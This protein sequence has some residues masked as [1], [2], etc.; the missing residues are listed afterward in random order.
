M[1][2]VRGPTWSGLIRLWG[3]STFGNGQKSGN[4]LQGSQ[5]R[6]QR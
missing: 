4:G 5:L 3:S 1:M 2:K 6:S